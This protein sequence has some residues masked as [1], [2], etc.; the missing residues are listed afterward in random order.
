MAIQGTTQVYGIIGFPITH[1]RSP[2]MQNAAFQATDRN[3]VYVPFEVHPDALA[4]A[5]SG[6]RALQVA[7]WNVTIP[8]KTTIMP[9]LDEIAPEAEAAGAVNVVV[10]RSGRLIGHNTD[11]AGL[12]A[13]LR[14][15]LGCLV[16]GQ[17]VVLLGSGGAARGAAAA[18][19]AAGAASVSIFNRT[20][21]TAHALVDALASRYAETSLAAYPFEQLSSSLP[22][23]GLLINTTSIGMRGEEIP[24]LRLDLLPK[25]AK[26]Y[27]MVY[28]N[29]VTPLIRAARQAG[30]QA[31][32][33]VGMLV[34]QGELA[35]RIWF[36][37]QPPQGGMRAAL[38][39]A[40]HTASA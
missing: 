4:A 24:G 12:L 40:L 15:D 39:V 23:A 38:E 18:L 29:P 11:G 37:D 6:L 21:E 27:D 14:D 2:V 3:A 32:D 33:G 36:G 9:L 17:Q 28:G 25:D 7:G 8:H 16:A 5:V 13:S 31:A 22:T 20:V 35:Y 1:S 34:A 10:N 30:L 26:V 19:C